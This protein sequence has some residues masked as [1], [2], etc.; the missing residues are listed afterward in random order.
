MNNVTK[1]YT[2]E[3]IEALKKISEA[4][5]ILTVDN[6]TKALGVS[7][8]TWYNYMDSVQEEKKEESK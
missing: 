5:K 7:K 8:Q 4:L 1:L 6:I 2:K 3:Q